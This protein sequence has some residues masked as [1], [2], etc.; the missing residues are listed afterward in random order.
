MSDKEH[1]RILNELYIHPIAHN[2]KWLELIPAL[3][4]VGVTHD[5][6]NGNHHF[7][8]G[9]HVVVFAQSGSETLNEDEVIKLRH[10]LELATTPEDKPTDLT[11]D[12][13]VAIT[14]HKAD[15]FY[16]PGELDESRQE[17][18]ADLKKSRVLHKRPTAPPYSNVGPIFDDDF[19]EDVIKDLAGARRIVILSHGKGSSN[20][21][22]QL[23]EKIH[24][25]HPE[26]AQKIAAI[27]SCDLEAMSEGQIVSLGKE[28]LGVERPN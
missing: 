11:N 6:K 15:I 13:I 24:H 3:S 27:Q 17:E 4:L 5:E 23:M 20:A 16:N 26:L 10:F 25:K 9:G 22:S 21:G 14:Y 8:H 2:I 1:A 18:H 7:T 12:V 19:F 28:L